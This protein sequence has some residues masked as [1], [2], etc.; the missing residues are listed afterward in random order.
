MNSNQL[1]AFLISTLFFFSVLIEK[2]AAEY[3]LLFISF[4]AIPFWIS[5]IATILIAINVNSSKKNK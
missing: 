5:L 1:C 4:A 2:G 3:P